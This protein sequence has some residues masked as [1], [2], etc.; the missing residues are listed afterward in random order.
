MADDVAAKYRA[1]LEGA[2]VLL[3]G[4]S[5]GV[6]VQDR[7][8][9]L[10]YA[11]DAAARI[12]GFASGR[13]MSNASLEQLLA[14]FTLSDEAGQ[15][16][17]DERLPA[18]RVLAGELN[19]EPVLMR[20]EQKQTGKA[21]WSL[22]RA[23]AILDEDGAPELAIT[24]WN[25]VTREHRAK[26]ASRHLA[27]A[28]KR[29]SSSLDYET[30]LT[31]VAEALVPALADWCAVEILTGGERKSLAVAHSDPAKVELARS[32]QLRYPPRVDAPTGVP[33]VYRT[34]RPELYPTIP[35]DSLRA[36]AHDEEHLR[37]LR[38]LGLRSAMIVPIPVAGRT[39]GV[40]TL[41]SA[42]SPRTYDEDDLELAC[43]IGRRAGTAIEHARVHEQAQSAIRA[44]DAFLA[45]A[46]HELRTPLAALMLQLE[47]VRAAMQSGRLAQDPDRFAL[48][49]AKTLGHARR[50]AGL[51][52]D[53][54]D[55]S[56][57]T[58]GHL[59]L[60][61]TEVDLAELART[62]VARF[63]DDAARAGA[64]LSLSAS[65]PCVGLWDKDRLDQVLSNLVSN[66]VKYSD[67]RPI[68]VSCEPA[69]RQAVVRVTDQGIGI[70]P[71]HHE[72][73]FGRFERA[74]SEHNYAGLGL[75][76]W[77]AREIVDAHGG[78][79]TVA[80]EPGAGST[81]LLELPYDQEGPSG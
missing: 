42:E 16:I 49:V 47:S 5:D 62:V 45:V 11:N 39:E 66:A 14:G 77:I 21:W 55:V 58:A 10:L 20:V 19:P 69:E 67:G 2:D 12:C 22:V 52:D 56:R 18:L 13:A 75:G 29:L 53:L 30:T 64:P 46:G 74:V 71:E 57:L 78:N 6:T 50:L 1:T 41:I 24:V 3:R 31:S 7:R 26:E 61:R 8:G 35:P 73:I 68:E 65:R 81:F 4:V 36:A 15:P 9:R 38:D 63:A 33:N 48:R 32:L 54:L 59:H 40:L 43:E 60:R 70:A 28:T 76:L 37:I 23:S 17:A 79:L 27:A 25:E 34:G 80:S 44:R 51:I 72:R